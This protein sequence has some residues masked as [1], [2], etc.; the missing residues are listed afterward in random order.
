MKKYQS[1]T[2]YAGILLTAVGAILFFTRVR[3]GNY[4][5]PRIGAFSTG[6]A[7]LV[8]WAVCLLLLVFRPG[9]ITKILLALVT[10]ALVISILL[11]AHIYIVTTSA[12]AM[13]GILA[14]L[15]GGIGLILRAV[16][17]Q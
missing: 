3:V 8:G 1:G 7:F 6:P 2:F 16:R 9:K 17:Q 13:F 10:L 14:L 11:S 5:F 12:L 4:L 15:F